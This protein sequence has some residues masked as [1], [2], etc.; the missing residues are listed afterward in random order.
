MEAGCEG[1]PF[2]SSSPASD[3]VEVAR[4]NYYTNYLAKGASTLGLQ[5]Y[6]RSAECMIVG[7][8]CACQAYQISQCKYSQAFLCILGS[9][10]GSFPF[11][12]NSRYAY[13][14]NPLSIYKMPT[15]SPLLG[16][17]I[18]PALLGLAAVVSA[19]RMVPLRLTAAKLPH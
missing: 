5:E 8:R 13:L 2:V 10:P 1:R 4:A 6:E 3:A 19:I 18:Q 14:V 9:R 11:V 17:P 7:R 16:H 15:C 12:F